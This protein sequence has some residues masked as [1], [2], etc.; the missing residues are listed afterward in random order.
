MFETSVN[1]WGQIGHSHLFQGKKVGDS[2]DLKLFQI[3]WKQQH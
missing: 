1:I 3:P 2:W